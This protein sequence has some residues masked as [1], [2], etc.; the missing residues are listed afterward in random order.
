[1][2]N[3][4]H[5][6][7]NDT[8]SVFQ[9][10]ITSKYPLRI[11]IYNGDTDAAC[12]FLGD[13]WFIEKLAKANEMTSTSRTEWNYTHP[14]GYLSRVGGW[15][16]GH[17]VPTDRP[18]PALQMIANFV[19]KTPYSTTVAYDVNSKPLLPEY[20]PTSAPP[21]NCVSLRVAYK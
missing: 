20:V 1:M 7:H 18:A 8:T 5:Q 10:I 12:N 21:G 16:G 2:N 14:G 9:S 19:K 15:G 3:N 6:Q 17:F 4:Y 13:E 11:L